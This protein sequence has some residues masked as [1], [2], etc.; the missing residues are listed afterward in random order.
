MT[1][2]RLEHELR[3]QP[4]AL[5]RLIERQG[6]QAERL[7]ALFPSQVVAFHGPAA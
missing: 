1:E 3:E 7:G 4:E 6:P 5:A 2:S